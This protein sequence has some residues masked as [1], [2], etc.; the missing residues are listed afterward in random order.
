MAPDYRGE[1]VHECT[2]E[3]WYEQIACIK[4]RD[5]IWAF[6]FS[7]QFDI[8]QFSDYSIKTVV[9]NN[10]ASPDSKPVNKQLDVDRQYKSCYVTL[11]I[12]Q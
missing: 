11:H 7:I 12:P 6:N 3:T 5:T 10:Q 8:T 1:N 4:G 2:I 9:A